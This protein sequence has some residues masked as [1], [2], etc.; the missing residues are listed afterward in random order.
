MLGPPHE[1]A[2]NR[3]SLHLSRWLDT[4]TFTRSDQLILAV[5]RSPEDGIAV[6]TFFEVFR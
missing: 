1:K 2:P 3:F 4:A 6:D 5:L